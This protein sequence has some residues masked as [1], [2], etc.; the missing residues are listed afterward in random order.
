[1]RSILTLLE[2][3]HHDLGLQYDLKSAQARA[4]EDYGAELEQMLTAS[5]SELAAVQQQAQAAV[6]A[7]QSELAAVQQRAQAAE[8][9]L[10]KLCLRFG[11]AAAGS[12]RWMR[13]C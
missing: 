1:M 8:A 4:A 9:E 12:G 5:R 10:G 3:Q 6:A 7:S 11:E 13:T 2:G